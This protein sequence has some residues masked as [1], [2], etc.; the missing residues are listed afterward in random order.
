MSE[1]YVIDAAGDVYTGFC[2]ATIRYGA[3]GSGKSFHLHETG[4]R[5]YKR[6]CKIICLNDDEGR[7]EYMFYYFPGR[8]DVWRHFCKTQLKWENVPEKVWVAI[9]TGEKTFYDLFPWDAKGYPIECYIPA[10]PGK[11]TYASVFKPFRICFSQ[12]SLTEFKL[13]LG[14]LTPKQ[15]RT[16]NLAWS[17]MIAEKKKKTFENLWELIKGFI[18]NKK[19]E[20]NDTQF[21]VCD[22]E[23]GADLYLKIDKIWQLGILTTKEDPLKLNLKEIMRD[24]KTITAFSFFN[25]KEED[26]NIRYVLYGY[27]LRRIRKLR[28]KALKDPAQ[29]A[30]YAELA[31]LVHELQDICPARGQEDPA[32]AEG[33]IAKIAKKPRDVM[34]WLHADT[35][36][37]SAIYK[38]VRDNFATTFIF[39]CER[40]VLDKIRDITW[41]DDGTYIGLQRAKTGVHCVKSKPTGGK[42]YTGVNFPMMSLPPTSLCKTPNDRF[43]A[44]WAAQGKEFIE[45][46]FPIRE[47]LI[48]SSQVREKK[49]VLSVKAKRIFEIIGQL[50]MKAI[51]RQ[52]GITIIELVKSPEVDDPEL[53]LGLSEKDVYEIADYLFEKGAI[54]KQ[55]EGRT[56]RCYIKTENPAPPQTPSIVTA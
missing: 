9:K 23:D 24:T 46:D 43:N 4:E 45:Y 42:D 7:D 17:S 20:V 39:R 36:D 18:S 37:P 2:S 25:I 52:P 51:R 38:P 21:T 54:D 10:V 11:N 33:Q 19:M 12:L 15:D 56:V 34:I 6:G 32:C 5:F 30:M 3:P 13:L 29:N 16:V 44:L 14:K 50:M 55:K 41:F 1:V 28:T 8:E 31:L 48:K 35:Q 47:T 53:A 22:S 40:V 27:I 26:E 49:T